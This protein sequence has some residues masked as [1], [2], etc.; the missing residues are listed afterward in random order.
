MP[1]ACKRAGIFLIGKRHV[2]QL[3]GDSP[4]SCFYAYGKALWTRRRSRDAPVGMYIP[5][6][7]AILLNDSW[8]QELYFIEDM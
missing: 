8:T 2:K 5:A 6:L 4:G 1:P 7:L 3:L